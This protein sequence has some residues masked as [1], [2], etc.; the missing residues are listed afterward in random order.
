MNTYTASHRWD[1]GAVLAFTPGRAECY[2][3]LSGQPIAALGTDQRAWLRRLQAFGFRATR[4]DLQVTDPDGGLIDLASFRAA[5]QGRHVLRF[6]KFTT[7]EQIDLC[8]GDPTGRGVSFGA[9]GGNGGGKH[10]RVYDKG[11]ESAGTVPGVRL[12]VEFSAD[13]ADAAF[14]ALCGAEPAAYMLTVAA[15]IGGAIDFR[16]FRPEAHHHADRRPRLGWWSR[17]LDVLGSA[18]L[19]VHRLR[20]N[21][22]RSAQVHA[23]AYAALLGKLVRVA[24]VQGMDGRQLVADHIAEVVAQG[25]ARLDRRGWSP[26]DEDLRTDFAAI[27]SGVPS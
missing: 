5:G 18:V 11:L 27:L 26:G 23:N 8:S 1:C 12:E 21:L 4:I 16:E 3:K 7:H 24:D 14:S 25:L 15:L 6:R 22:E 10:V 17:I 2:L 9:R 13:H 19:A 20:C